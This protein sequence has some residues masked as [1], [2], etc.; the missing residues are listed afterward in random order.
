MKKLT[1][2]L[3]VLP[4]LLSACGGSDNAPRPTVTLAD[5]GSVKSTPPAG[6]TT[7]SG[8]TS[9]PGSGGGVAGQPVAL[10][11]ADGVVM[12]AH[13]YATQA[14]KR[15]VVILAHGANED[16]KDWQALAQELASRGVAA[17]TLDFRGF[18]ETGG[19]RDT[20]KLAD[21]L[22]TAVRYLKSEDWPLVYIV[23]SDIGG[24]AAL[25]VAA[26][27]ELAGVVTISALPRV[28]GLDAMS[29]VSKIVEPKLFLAASGDSAAA[30]AVR[31]MAGVASEP[32]MS[33]IVE[34]TTSHGIVLLQ[35]ATAKQAL[36]TFIN[37]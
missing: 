26:N 36:L 25:K 29:D 14:P 34:G 20:S 24:T 13:L 10:Q 4:L 31:I 15:K 18:G 27:E 3:L 1:T 5:S 7:P 8:P 21:D 2:L 6:P 22:A 37:P 19:T 17:L 30:S 11:A 9:T 23:G 12:R 33:L 16:Q 28:T 35:V 32:K